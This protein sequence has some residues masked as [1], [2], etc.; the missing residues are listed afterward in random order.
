MKLNLEKP[1]IFFD[2]ETTGIDKVKD[3]VVELCY[4]KLFPDGHEEEKTMRIRPTDIFGNTVHIPEEASAVN[5]IYDDDVKDCPSFKQVAPELQKVFSDSDLAGYNSDNYD[6]PLLVEEFLRAGINIDFSS[7]KCVDV[8][9]IYKKLCPRTLTAAYMQYCHKDL[10]DAHSAMADTRA[11]LDVLQAQLEAHADVLQN[12]I[13]YLA[14][15]PGENKNVDYSGRMVYNDQGEEIFNF[16]KHKGKKV[17]DVILRL[18]PG[19]YNWMMQG[20]FAE[21]TKQKLTK[22][23]LRETSKR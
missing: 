21:E 11:T 6:I 22:I 1:I 17:A 7:A 20:D 13:A 4:I 15:F 2:L 14:T 9:K 5:G 8:C 10:E 18:D 16:G 23:R 12:D 3:H 19:Y